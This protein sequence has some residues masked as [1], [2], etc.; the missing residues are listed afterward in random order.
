MEKRTGLSSAEASRRLTKF[1]PNTIV[2]VAAVT[3]LQQL[4]SQFTSPLVILLLLATGFSL[5]LGETLDGILILTIVILNALLGFVQEFKAEK[6]LEALKK[7]T[8]STVR[9]IRDGVQRELDAAQLVP[10]DS[11]VLEEGDKVP[12][13]AKLLESMH[14]E[15]NEASLTGESFPV[16]KSAKEKDNAGVFLGTI[17]T[18]GRGV[19]EV[20]TTGS[21]TKF[22]AIATKLS[23]MKEEP[24]PL[25][26]RL[27]GV[28]K[29]LGLLA[30]VAA[31]GIL[32]IGFF[33]KNP[34]IEIVLTAISLAVAAVPEG[35]PAVI[36]I[37]LAIGTQRMAKRRAILRKLAA[38]EALGSI[39]VIAT[40]KTGTITKNQMQV[41]DVWLDGKAYKAKDGKLRSSPLFTKLL[42]VGV[43]CNNASLAPRGDHGGHDV[44]GDQTEGSL[45]LLA[46]DHKTD[47]LALR[48]EGKLVEE[49]G[50]DPT[51]K[52]MSVVWKEGA[53]TTIL[54]K[55]APE[56]IL[57]RS[58]R[59][60][61][62]KEETTLSRQKKD[63][64]FTA[65][66]SFAKLGL[67]VI[68]L[69]SKKITWN[70]QSREDAESNLTFIGFVG[71]ADPAREEVGEA[72]RVARD[73]GIATI[74][75]TGDNELTALAIAKHIG[76]IERGEEVITGAQFAGMRD[77]E[78]KRHLATTRVFARTTPEQ[79]LEI[80]RLL[81]QQ[82]HVVAVTGDGVNDALALK[83]ADVGVAMG[84][85][86]TDVAKE[87]A[88]MIV[89]DDNYATIVEAVAEGRT[90]FDNMKSSV[91]YLIGCNVGEVVAILGGA[92]LGW[93]FV[94]TPIQILYVNLATDGIPALALAV[95]PKHHAVMRRKPRT[96]KGLF[97][98]FDL[99][100]FAEVS[101]LTGVSTLLAFW[102][103]WKTGNIGVARALA[104]TVVILAQQFIFWDI[105]AGDRQLLNPHVLKN[106][107]LMLP[108]AIMGIQ[109]LI[110]FLP[111]LRA[112]FSLAPT[113]TQL[114][115]V[116]ALITSV[117]LITTAV[118]KRFLRH[119][120]YQHS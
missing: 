59:I 84:I 72:I 82:G 91:K 55:G 106:P 65:F 19:A 32:I 64:I 5:V 81:Q 18:H 98:K 74:M 80:V 1:G 73:A 36:T 38:I 24:T 87:A 107:W 7:M 57:E 25:E 101:L 2:H 52:T 21:A 115:A 31:A 108:F 48:Q 89:T 50:F 76:L 41:A 83:Q 88:E 53:T 45:L 114:L 117:M 51:T 102:L 44:I 49:F 58:T 69:A 47:I 43:R 71:I 116:S 66:E 77:E 54:T 35:L 104:F 70:N 75:I 120:Y 113:T 67:R 30:G 22:G 3:P 4:L 68:A 28:A 85:T 105:A 46:T 26:K 60:A 96:G 99:R 118:R 8:V 92:L 20:M 10:G 27:A 12:A 23:L 13:D 6:A 33:H 39:T 97:T 79:K 56:S 63:Q 119:F 11:I 90:I 93:P 95:T 15:V 86:G 16:E 61:M 100:W 14:M 94:L 9:V 17:V 40:D 110:L 111:G 42:T 78:K 103:G 112:I 62:G 37:T 29:Q 109:V 34:L